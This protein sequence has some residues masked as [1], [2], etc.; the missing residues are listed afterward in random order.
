MGT[1]VPGVTFGP[2]GFIAPSESA[3]L[4]GTL[5]DI[6]AAFALAGFNLNPK[7]TTPQGQIAS[8]NAAIIG[9][10]NAT[11]LFYTQQVDPAYATGRMQDA[12]ARIYFITRN[13]AQPTVV[14]CICTGLAG[15]AIPSGALAADSAGNIYTCTEGGTIPSGGST[16]LAFA[17][18]AVGPIPCP[19]G[20]LTIIY[21]AIPGWDSIT[22][23]QDG[24]LGSNVETRQ[25]FEARRA[26]SV[27]VNSGG[28]LGS[29]LGAVL[30]VPGVLDAY[31]T[32]NPTGAPVTVGGV[33]LAANS[34]YVAVVGGAEDA[35]AQAIWS[36]KAPGCAYN[37]NTT[38]DV[39]DEN[40]VYNGNGPIYPV[41]FEIPSSLSI[42][43]AVTLFDN[44]GIPS[45]AV[46]LIQNAIIAAFAG[47][48][49]GPKASI[50]A[51]VLA[52]RFYST[53]AAL[54]PWALIESLYV[55]SNNEETAI[56]SG[57]IAGTVMTVTEVFSGTLAIGQALS[58]RTGLVT[59]GTLI[60]SG[61]G[62]T[63][64]VTPSEEVPGAAFTGNASGAN[65]TVSAVT[66][67]IVPG[68]ALHGTGVPSGTT[69]LSQTSGTVGGA[70][71]YVTSA[72]TTASSASLTADDLFT[73]AVPNL[74]SVA[75]NINQIPTIAAANIQVATT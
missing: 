19:E 4:A 60:V 61:S 8:S 11:F 40:P 3:V 22:N 42:L 47:S 57:T 62:S 6:L 26:A 67:T 41:T 24:V 2:N 64:G 16:T 31:V 34:V 54:G 14:E 45:N 9:N 28:A 27:G 1:N 46:S 36:R 51:T 65:L 25:A 10:T 12:L 72:V 58:D 75:V 63:W 35:V 37:G 33:T 32:E 39:Q 5:A 53:V 13:P 7:L 71:V 17:N 69:I 44:V 68:M 48:D 52:S 66:G 29:I 15:V 49:G 30:S 20:T 55:G 74:N 38:V 43:F 18:Q 21:Q 56:F 73:A 59:E 23:G 70:G 50:G